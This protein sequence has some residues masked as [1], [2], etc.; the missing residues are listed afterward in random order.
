MSQYWNMARIPRKP[1][2]IPV[3]TLSG[4]FISCLPEPR[5]E[6]AAPFIV[7]REKG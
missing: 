4:Y 3:R 5:E 6:D 7:Q 2:L 1:V